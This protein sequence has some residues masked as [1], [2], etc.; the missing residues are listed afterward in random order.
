MRPYLHFANL[1]TT[2]SLASGFFAIVLAQDGRLA[3]AFSAVLV[4][5]ALDAV[6]GYAARRA[7]VAGPFGCQLDSLADLVAFGVAPALMLH[8]AALD[9]MPALGLVACT[10]FVAA[11]AWRLARF[12][13]VHD[14][15][16]FVGLPIPVA[17]I[18]AGAVATLG[19]TGAVALA[20]CLVLALLMVSSISVPTLAGL[21]GLTRRRRP[22]LRLVRS[23]GAAD[24]SRSGQRP[25]AR[26]HDH[27][28]D[29][30]NRDEERI[31]APALARE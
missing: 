7:D 16:R 1:L 6:D 9:A 3:A 23:D 29:A 15:Q 10:G 21:G 11:G 19:S 8:E 28:R 5:A 12:A 18:V 13:V 31:R 30:E 25:R 17:G 4:A 24:G 27:E 22:A 20:L 14:S 2:G 26:G